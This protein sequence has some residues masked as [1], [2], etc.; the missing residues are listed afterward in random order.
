ML[1]HPCGIQSQILQ[2]ASKVARSFQQLTFFK[3]GPF[4]R[5]HQPVDSIAPLHVTQ[6]SCQRQ[7]GSGRE[8]RNQCARREPFNWPI[9]LAE[10]FG[11]AD[12]NATLSPDSHHDGFEA[13]VLAHQATR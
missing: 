2:P 8:I 9:A 7:T 5:A 11:Q 6:G 1:R 12:F 3:R 10:H 13:L 4:Y